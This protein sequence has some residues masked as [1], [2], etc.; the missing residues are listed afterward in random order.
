MKKWLL[1]G[2]LG[3]V[4]S[5]LLLNVDAVNTDTKQPTSSPLTMPASVL[6]NRYQP[7]R[8]ALDRLLS[9]L[10]TREVMPVYNRRALPDAAD[11]NQAFKD[12]RERYTTKLN[13]ANPIEILRV[14]EELSKQ[15]LA[16]ETTAAQYY[17]SFF[18]SSHQFVRGGNYDRA[19][20]QL[21][22]ITT[23]FSTP[24]SVLLTTF[25]QK[26]QNQSTLDNEL[27][28]VGWLNYGLLYQ[29]WTVGNF[30][31][32]A[33]QADLLEKLKGQF[34]DEIL[35]SYL[36][37]NLPKAREGLKVWQAT[38]QART[39]LKSEPDN[40]RANYAMAQYY[41]YQ[42]GSVELA[43]PYMAKSGDAQLSKLAEIERAAEV[44][45]KASYPQSNE[46]INTD[47]FSFPPVP[48]NSLRPYLACAD[49]WME[50]GA[51]A[52]PETKQCAWARAAILYDKIS[53]AEL[54]DD[55]AKAKKKYGEIRTVCEQENWQ[56]NEK[57]TLEPILGNARG[58]R[59][60]SPLNYFGV[61]SEG[62]R[63][64]YI[65]DYSGSM[66][67]IFDLLRD[68]TLRSLD[69]LASNQSFAII[70]YSEDVTILGPA[71]LQKATQENKAKFQDKLKQ[72]KHPGG[73][74]DDVI[75]PITKTFN[76]AFAMKPEVI[77]FL[78]DGAFE[79]QFLEIIQELN[80][81][82]KV[83]I[84]TLAFIKEDPKYNERLRKLAADNNGQYKLIQPKE[85]KTK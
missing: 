1:S 38:E 78:T 42:F 30:D 54:G 35:N 71:I 64:V 17:A 25:S 66:I 79:L 57:T 8:I 69:M 32:V 75:E 21:L 18:E 23:K 15:A 72:L 68:E 46:P 55:F 73:L 76:K 36:A 56:K 53:R 44:Q 45:S 51:K 67:D 2:I 58:H 77:Y 60:S 7:I 74:N 48:A 11:T 14:A 24:P 22:S 50:Y 52:T 33:H 61:E 19:C 12:L 34:K 39:T 62:T 47:I 10:N 83:T 37:K 49:A 31:I 5:G 26:I 4:A 82:K 84:N 85:P 13:K 70:L 40:P 63:I 43:V 27:I 20:K 28:F 41:L 9:N 29:A 80:K 16:G 81:E 59:A 65:L 6:T 3:L